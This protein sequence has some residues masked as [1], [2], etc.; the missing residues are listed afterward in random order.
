MGMH[1]TTVDISRRNL[2]RGRVRDLGQLPL[3]PPWA[4]LSSFH[5]LCSRC[6]DCIKSCE[7]HVIVMTD[8]GFPGVNFKQGE[9]S[10]C[11][12]CVTVCKT[13]ALSREIDPPWSMVAQINDRCLST[14][15]ITCR[16]C[17][18]VCDTRAIRFKLKVGGRADLSIENNKCTGCGACVSVCPVDAVSVSHMLEQQPESSLDRDQQ[19]EIA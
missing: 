16:S 14:K 18:D 1:S 3:R 7:E 19:E 15:G 17:G 13:G 8:G 10:F 12:D 4:V 2:L 6:G 5:T 11:G 9:C